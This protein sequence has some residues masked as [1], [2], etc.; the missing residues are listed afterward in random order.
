MRRWLYG[1]RKAAAGWEEDY[2]NKMVDEGFR[3]GRGA[4]TVF[5]NEKT[6]IM[7]VVHGG[8]FAFCGT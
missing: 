5:H 3:R 2:A 4:P 8:D 6:E 7:A 1:T